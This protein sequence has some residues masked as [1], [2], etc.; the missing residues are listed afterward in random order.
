ME[1]V[2][3]HRII[4]EILHIAPLGNVRIQGRVTSLSVPLEAWPLLIILAITL[5]I[6]QQERGGFSVV[7]KRLTPG[8]GWKLKPLYIPFGY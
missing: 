5:R 1:E 7:S 3:L 2:N 6:W 8:N 4:S